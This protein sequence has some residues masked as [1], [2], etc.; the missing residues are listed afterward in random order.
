LKAG[1]EDKPIRAYLRRMAPELVERFDV[2]VEA[3]DQEE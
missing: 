2:L 1:K 3:S